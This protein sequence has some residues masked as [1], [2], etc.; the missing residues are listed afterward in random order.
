MPSM[1]ASVPP[2]VASVITPLGTVLDTPSLR[3]AHSS[4]KGV[5]VGT[6]LGLA[7]VGAV[8]LGAQIAHRSSSTASAAAPMLTEAPAPPPPVAATTVATEPPTPPPALAA[9]ALPAVSPTVEPVKHPGAQKAPRTAALVAQAVTPKS[10]PLPVAPAAST[11]PPA[12]PAEASDESAQ[13]LIP[14]IPPSTPV[15]D[16]L[17]K[18]VQQDIQ[19]DQQAHGK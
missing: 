11:A 5:Y 12:P 13:S 18:A 8:I 17:V 6:V 9:T 16:P 15:V 3:P 4:I 7:I 10:A 14:V 1:H 19:E 2:V